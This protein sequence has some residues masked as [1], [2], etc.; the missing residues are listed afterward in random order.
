MGFF[1]SFWNYR[2]ACSFD[3][4]NFV[5]TT[6]AVIN[7]VAI[8]VISITKIVASTVENVTTTVYNT[9]AGKTIINK[10]ENLID[11]TKTFL[12]DKWN[13]KKNWFW[14]QSFG[15]GINKA[16]EWIMN[17]TFIGK[18]IRLVKRKV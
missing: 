7:A 4:S 17:D 2:S 3:L 1:S 18:W 12:N 13:E 16:K 8:T 14:N 6:V 10:V 9:D 11:K 15:K 5:S